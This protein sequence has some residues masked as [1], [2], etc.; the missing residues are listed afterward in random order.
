MSTGEYMEIIALFIS[1]TILVFV[2]VGLIVNILYFVFVERSF[3]AA[4]IV[5]FF[6]TCLFWM[7]RT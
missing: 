4:I 2:I 7:L 1:V 5:L 6:T 3:K